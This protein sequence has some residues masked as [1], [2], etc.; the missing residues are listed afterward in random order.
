M[1][2]MRRG[3]TNARSFSSGAFAAAASWF[4]VFLVVAPHTPC[5]CHVVVPLRSGTVVSA[6]E[7]LPPAHKKDLRWVQTARSLSDDTLQDP[8]DIFRPRGRVTLQDDVEIEIEDEQQQQQ[9]MLLGHH[10]LWGE[11]LET[12]YDRLSGA[13]DFEAA[14]SRW[15]REEKAVQLIVS[16]DSKYSNGSSGGVLQKMLGREGEMVDFLSGE[17]YLV[18]VTESHLEDFTR[19]MREMAM[20][21]EYEGKHK[22]PPEMLALL[23]VL[24]ASNVTTSNPAIESF[25]ITSDMS[26]QIVSRDPTTISIPIPCWTNQQTNQLGPRRIRICCYH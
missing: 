13:S 21:L 26:L 7:F 22:V 8:N 17:R 15:W 9:Q 16:F 11:H 20:V 6:S 10:H 23:Q 3:T 19:K 25:H 1:N 4:L 12:C 14:L 5:S 18:I 2:R 24:Q